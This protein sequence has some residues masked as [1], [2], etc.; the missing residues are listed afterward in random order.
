MKHNYLFYVQYLGIRYAG[1]QKQVGVRTVQGTLE[2]SFRYLLGEGRCKILGAGRTD[3]GVSAN[4]A[5]FELFSPVPIDMNAIC[6]QVNQYLPADIRLLGVREVGK[7]FNIIHDVVWKEYR[8]NLA[9]GKK[10]HPFAGGNLSYFAGDLD[11]DL[12]KRGLALLLGTHD[13]RQFCSVDKVTNNYVRTILETSLSRHPQAGIGYVPN[14]SHTIVFKGKGFLRYQVRIM[15]GALV[16]LGM[17][18]LSLEQFEAALARPGNGPIAVQ[19]PPYG[20]VLEDVVF[21]NS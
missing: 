18:K 12:M 13:F 8:Y 17:G 16:D 21:R 15:V 2:R 19:A 20:L 9:F 5:A 11:I 10:F 14:D 1:W 3:A 6:Y 7:D 4:R